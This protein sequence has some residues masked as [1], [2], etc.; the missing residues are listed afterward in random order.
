MGRRQSRRTESLD[1]TAEA[2]GHP[3]LTKLVL[4][5]RILL[6]ELVPGSKSEVIN[7]AARTHIAS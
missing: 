6:L 5:V 7:I 2:S 3:Y 4:E 1:Q